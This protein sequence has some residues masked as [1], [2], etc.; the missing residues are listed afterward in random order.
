[1]GFRAF[2]C[3]GVS[4]EIPRLPVRLGVSLGVKLPATGHL[5]TKQDPVRYAY[6]EEKKAWV[7]ID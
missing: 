2:T 7:T 1:M 5:E 6:A 4:W 3:L